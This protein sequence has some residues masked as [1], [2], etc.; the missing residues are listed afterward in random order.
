MELELHRLDVR[1]GFHGGIRLG[2]RVVVRREAYIAKGKMNAIDLFVL[3]DLKNWLGTGYAV[4]SNDDALLAKLITGISADVLRQ[5]NRTFQ[6]GIQTITET[7]DGTGTPTM[8]TR[9]FPIVTVTG[10]S[11][12]TVSLNPSSNGVNPGFTWGTFS[13][14]LVGVPPALLAGGVQSQYLSSPWIFRVG[15]QNVVL[16]YTGGYALTAVVGELNTVPASSPYQF[17]PVNV[18]PNYVD[19]GLNYFIGG[20]ALTSVGNTSPTSAGKYGFNPNTS[21]YYF[22]VADAGAQILTNYS[23]GGVPLDLSQVLIEWA[24]QRYL[25]RKHIGLR[26]NTS[27]AG[28]QASYDYEIPSFVQAVINRY[29]GQPV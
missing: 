7:R 3:Q 18:G 25:G 27:K 4:P 12:D 1:R 29:K 19:Q 21:T 24:A 17:N 20:A 28:E 6:G 16:N 9:V 8:V 2:A 22:N 13:I 10:V 26:S 5:L 15:K 11:I 14:K 23:Y